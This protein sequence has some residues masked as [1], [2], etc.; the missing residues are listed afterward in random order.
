MPV[1]VFTQPV[2]DGVV[3]ALDSGSGEIKW[4]IDTQSR[5][6]GGP[7]VGEALVLLGSREGE[8]IALTTD[9]GKELWRSSCN[10]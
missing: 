2:R 4:R 1:N 9:E 10:Q 8:V 5:L 6:G 3:T 7:G